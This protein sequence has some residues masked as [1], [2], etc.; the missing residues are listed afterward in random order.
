VEGREEAVTV[1]VLSGI[2]I[3]QCRACGDVKAYDDRDLRPLPGLRLEVRPKGDEVLGAKRFEF[4]S[5]RC[6]ADYAARRA[7]EEVSG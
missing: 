6:L 5:W 1:E 4:C 3:I 7:G 2:T